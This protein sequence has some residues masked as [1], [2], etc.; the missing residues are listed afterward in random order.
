MAWDSGFVI[1]IETH[2][3][4]FKIGNSN[5]NMAWESGF[6]IVIETWHEIQDW[7]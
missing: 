3:M 4:R 1:V 5:W 2:G 6:E 7:K